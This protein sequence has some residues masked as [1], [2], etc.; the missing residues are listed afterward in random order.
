MKDYVNGSGKFINYEGNI[1]SGVWLNN[2][3]DNLT[4][5]QSN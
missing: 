3:L 2:K 4:I 5:T 1:I